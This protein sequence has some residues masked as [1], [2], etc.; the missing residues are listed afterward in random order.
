MKLTPLQREILR[1]R[2]EVPDAIGDSLENSYDFDAAQ[3]EAAF[4]LGP[5]RVLARIEAGDYPANDVETAILMDLVQNSTYYVC[6]KAEASRQY[7]SAVERAG[8]QLAE[9]VSAQ[10]G[11]EIYFPTV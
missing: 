8:K 3:L 7:Q 1:H 6:G 5:D 9:M 4:E 11:C 10:V 2:L